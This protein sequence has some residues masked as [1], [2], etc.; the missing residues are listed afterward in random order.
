MCYAG[1][2]NI[3]FNQSGLAVNAWTLV[4]V[5]NSLGSKRHTGLALW[6]I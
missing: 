1:L 3:W 6:L 2:N 5:A 4:N